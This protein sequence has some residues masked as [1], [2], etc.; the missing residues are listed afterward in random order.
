MTD[1]AFQVEEANTFVRITNYDKR[2]ENAIRE[3][4]FK[5]LTSWDK[6]PGEHFNTFKFVVGHVY[7]TFTPDRKEFRLN[8]SFYKSLKEYL[9]LKGFDVDGIEVNLIEEV[10]PAEANFEWKNIVITPRNESQEEYLNFLLREDKRLVVINAGT[11]QGKALTSNT[12]VKTP[13]GWKPIGELKVNDKVMAWDNTTTKVTGVYPQGKLQVNKITFHDGRNCYACD[14]HLWKVFNKKWEVLT[15]KE[16]KS[17]CNNYSIPLIKPFDKE[18]NRLP[19]QPEE[20]GFYLGYVYLYRYTSNYFLLEELNNLFSSKEYEELHRYTSIPEQYFITS[21]KQREEILNSLVILGGEKL[22]FTYKEIALDIQKLIWS[23]G[24]AITL[25]TEK[26][27]GGKEVYSL[28]L[29]EGYTNVNN[30]VPSLGI[31]NIESAGVEDCTCIS[32]DHPDKLFIVKDFIVTHNTVITIMGFVKLGYRVIITIL[33]RY[34]P[35][36]IEAFNKFLKLNPEDILNVSDHD[37]NDV[38]DAFKEG[39]INPKIVFFQL[40]RIDTYIKRMREFPDSLPHLDDFFKVMQ[41]G[42]RIID[43]AHESIYSVYSSMLYGNI[44][45]NVAL[46]ATLRG[47]NAFI[48]KIYENTFPPEAYLKAPI[49]EK[50][51]RVINYLHRM[52]VNK[53]KVRTVSFGGYSHVLYEQSILKKKFIFD[54]YYQMCKEAFETHYLEN[55]REGQKAMFFFSTV[56]MC[57]AFADSLKRDYPDLDIFVFTG[58]ISKKKGMAQEYARHDIVITTPTSCGT[59]KDIEKLFVV[60]AGVSVSSSQRVDQMAGRLRSIE[61]W[62]SDLDPIYLTF[63]CRDVKKQIEY[64]GKRKQVLNKTAKSVELIDSGFWI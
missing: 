62:W 47:D 42:V 36:W 49:Y 40:T 11:G 60:F 64:A 38:Y 15:T 54:K 43:E 52:N 13:M 27:I 37:I 29:N 34:V 28:D 46:S 18:N 30:Q 9:N 25:N 63:V 23:L 55:K 21:K 59:G 6:V 20:L 17:N 44:N 24:H 57:N 31:K 48:N 19:F 5:N 39:I 14:E 50:Y 26:L 32:V 61:K 56:K 7:A 12:A 10:E 51:I 22:T 4:C 58:E 2:I 8:K 53:Y 35:I 3:F 41:G 1:L 45:K 33:P 16:I